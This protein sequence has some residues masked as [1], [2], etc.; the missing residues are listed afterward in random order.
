MDQFRRNTI[1]VEWIKIN[2]MA[3]VTQLQ[4]PLFVETNMTLGATTCRKRRS[5]LSR[6]IMPTSD[7]YARAAVCW[8]GHGPLCMPNLGHR[9]EWCICHVVPD[10]MLDE[11]CLR[12]NLWHRVRFQRLRTM[13][14]S[15][16][17]VINNG[18]LPCKQ[19]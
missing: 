15:R 1:I 17:N 18:C 7:E 4:V 8:I 12:L 14:A 2:T 19:V 6:L 5:F 13:R 16:P 3:C 9:L 10:W 11:L